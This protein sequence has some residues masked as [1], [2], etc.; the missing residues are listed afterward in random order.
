MG[1]DDLARMALRRAANG[2]LDDGVVQDVSMVH[3]EMLDSGRLWL[4]CYLSGTGVDGDRVTFEIV[5]RGR[6]LEFQ[7]VEE[8]RGTVDVE[9]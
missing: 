7:V 1:N 5:A 2:W 9:S 6:R 4:C 8:P 3:A